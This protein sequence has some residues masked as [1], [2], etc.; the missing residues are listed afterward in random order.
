M[1]QLEAAGTG[2]LAGC[3]DARWQAESLAFRLSRRLYERRSGVRIGEISVETSSGSCGA[4]GSGVTGHGWTGYGALEM[5][6]LIHSVNPGSKEASNDPRGAYT[7]RC[8]GD[9]HQEG[10]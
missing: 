5:P 10:C 3:D 6:G 4:A 2:S 9:S 1:R 8:S 7:D